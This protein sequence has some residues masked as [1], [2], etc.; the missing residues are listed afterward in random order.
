[1]DLLAIYSYSICPFKCAVYITSIHF[2]PM[3]KGVVFSMCINL[4][5]K[6]FSVQSDSKGVCSK[7]A[8]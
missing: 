1:M 5:K 3:K 7:T 2:Y 8:T 4:F 6:K